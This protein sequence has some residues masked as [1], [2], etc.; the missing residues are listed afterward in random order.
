MTDHFLRLDLPAAHSD[1]RVARNVIRHFARLLGVSNGEL[2]QLGLVVSELLANAID[3][4]GG[5]AA[6]NEA[7]RTTDVRMRLEFVIREGEWELA[8]TDQGGGDLEE[9]RS[10]LTPPDG[11]PDLDDDRGRG[12]FLLKQMVDSLE[13]AESEDSGGLTFSAIRR[14]GD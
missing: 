14:Y 11:I 7:D 2:D 1:V 9:V 10:F 12:F 8:V 13:V 6:L 3:H 5:G 4:G